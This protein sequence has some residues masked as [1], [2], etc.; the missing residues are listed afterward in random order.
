MY[1]T[2]HIRVWKVSSHHSNTMSSNMLTNSKYLKTVYKDL[3][4]TRLA[5]SLDTSDEAFTEFEEAYNQATPTEPEHETLRDAV[6][7]FYMVN[8]PSFERWMTENR[9][10]HLALWAD[11]GLAARVL[12]L[13]GIVFIRWNAETKR[14]ECRAHQRC[15]ETI[16]QLKA[17]AEANALQ[18]K[19]YQ[20]PRAALRRDNREAREGRPERAPRPP[21]EDRPER[22]ARS[23]RAPRPPREP[24]V[25]ARQR[26][27]DQEEK[28]PAPEAAP[29]PAEN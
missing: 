18:R 10:R 24:R 2:T 15:E 4:H 23:E 8:R 11:C 20:A 6:R 5:T 16:Q 1:L 27:R 14:Y 22:P 13:D 3:T 19:R 17:E 25:P 29:A 28:D 12:G 7:F 21:R 9:Q 26:R